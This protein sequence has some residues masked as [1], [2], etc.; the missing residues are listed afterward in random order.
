MQNKLINVFYHNRKVGRLAETPD[1]LLA[2][3]YDPDWLRDGFS[4]SPF[5]LPL[6]KRVFIAARDPFDGS[7][8]VFNDSLPDGWGRLLINRLLIKNKIDLASVSTLDRLAIVGSSG[9][10][11]LEYRPQER[12]VGKIENNNLDTLA[13][14]VE[15]ILNENY[16][17]QK[18]E[19]LVKLGGSSVGARP[20]VL[21]RIKNEDWLIKF[22]A[23]VDPKNIGEKEFAYM[24]A[25]KAAGLVVPQTRLFESK[26]FGVKRF[27]RMKDANPAQ[28]TRKIFM[29]SAC[30]LLDASHRFPTLDYNSLMTLT[31]ELTR[32]FREVVKMFRLMCF[33]VLTHNRDDHSKNFS[34]LFSD[35]KWMLSPAYDLVYSDGLNGEHAAAINGEGRNPTED[36]IMAV[37]KNSGLDQKKAKDILEEVKVVAKNLLFQFPPDCLSGPEISKQ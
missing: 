15:E 12:L 18:L 32:D 16:K 30:G 24:A 31:M 9:M 10:G 7:F 6:L 1:K 2:F 37:A 19:E 22:R 35:K 21:L 13:R 20:K 23:A 34:F 36:H 8:G 26:Y 11:A 27:D 28:K 17:G 33:N 4:I 14:E 5:K 25:A 29:I 3:E